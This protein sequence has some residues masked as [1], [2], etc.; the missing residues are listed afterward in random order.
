MRTL[1]VI[2]LVA[3]TALFL[4]ACGA[5]GEVSQPVATAVQQDVTEDA[6][7]M[8]DDEAEGSAGAETMTEAPM[9]DENSGGEGT[10]TTAV[11]EESMP[12]EAPQAEATEAEAMEAK[13]WGP[14]RPQCPPN[15]RRGSRFP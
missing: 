9:V 10:T 3:S 5:Q 2:A 15:V 13:Q 6:G 4:G 14:K 11:E 8:V 1:I 12:V 7:E